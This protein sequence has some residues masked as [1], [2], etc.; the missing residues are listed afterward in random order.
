MPG[1]DPTDFA[2]GFSSPACLMH[3]VDPVYMGL[4]PEG[5]SNSD[6]APWRQA[7]RK[8]LINARMD[9]SFARRDAFTADIAAKLDDII[10]DASGK[11][12][13]FFWPFKGEP[14]LR[15]WMAVVTAKGGTTLLPVVIAKGQPLVFRSWK[16]GEK[17]EPG[18]WNIPVPTNGTE[19]VPDIVIAPVVGFDTACFRL[20]YG[21]GF[22]DRTLA[23]FRHSLLAI[24]V[25][26]EQQSI[27]SIR[28][29]PHDIPMD[30][31]VTEHRVLYR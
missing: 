26:Y 25:G 15:Q 19:C 3:E 28:P 4:S 5:N 16:T 6:V 17:L 31:V 30:I 1:D 11:S 27:A 20:G 24:G 18:V 13:S 7:E 14:D 8:R 2:D 12:V 10:G 29:Q 21:G 9:I 22:F 23:R